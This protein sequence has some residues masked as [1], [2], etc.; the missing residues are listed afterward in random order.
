MGTQK[1]LAPID[2]GEHRCKVEFR[3]KV[4][5]KGRSVGGIF[6]PPRLGK[7]A[8]IQICGLLPEFELLTAL[9]HELTHFVAWSEGFTL[10]EARTEMLARGFQRIFRLNPDL[11]KFIT[12]HRR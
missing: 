10:G 2:D 9:F 1:K 11:A 7:D 4:L 6:S 8:Y 5:Y 12:T 3:E